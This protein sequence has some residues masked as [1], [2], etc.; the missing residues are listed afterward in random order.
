M[1]ATIITVVGFTFLL[2]AY[3]EYE[4]RKVPARTE[5]YLKHARKMERQSK[6]QAS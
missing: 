5:A 2:I 3:M 1:I 6:K 4:F